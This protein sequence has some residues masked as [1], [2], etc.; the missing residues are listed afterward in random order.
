MAVTCLGKVRCRHNFIWKFKT[1]K[2]E[3]YKKN[4]KNELPEVLSVSRIIKTQSFACIFIFYFPFI[5]VNPFS[6]KANI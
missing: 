2:Q 3:L 1:S 5:L 6:L 4:N